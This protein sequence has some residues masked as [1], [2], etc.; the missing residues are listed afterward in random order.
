VEIPA[1]VGQLANVEQATRMLKIQNSKEIKLFNNS[2]KNEKFQ[3]IVALVVQVLNAVAVQLANVDKRK[4]KV[5]TQV[6]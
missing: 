1:V 4:A 6:K 3:D 2:K 5:F